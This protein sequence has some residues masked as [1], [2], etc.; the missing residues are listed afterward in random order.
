MKIL[1]T[2]SFKKSIKRLHHN[3]ISDL[4]NS[5]R[6]LI[7]TL[8]IGDLKKGDLTEVRVYK[9]KMKHSLILLAYIYDDTAQTITLLKFG[10]HENF[11]RDLKAEIN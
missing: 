1:Q 10:S 9:F 11:Y 7:Q 5:I 6:K 4:D 3:Q 2:V 8:F